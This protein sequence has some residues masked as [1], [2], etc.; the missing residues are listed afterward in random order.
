[1]LR[2]RAELRKMS[3]FQVELICFNFM[4]VVS[5][6]RNKAMKLTRSLILSCLVIVACSTQKP[7]AEQH[8]LTQEMPI[9]KDRESF[10]NKVS[11]GPS[12]TVSRTELSSSSPSS[13][14]LAVLVENP[15]EGGSPATSNGPLKTFLSGT[16]NTLTSFDHDNREDGEGLAQSWEMSSDGRQYTFHLKRGREWHSS[17]RGFSPSHEMNAEDVVFT[18]DRFMN[19]KNPLHNTPITKGNFSYWQFDDMANLV[20]GVEA[21]D[22][23]TVVFKL[24]QP[25]YLFPQIIS[26]LLLKR[27][28]CTTWPKVWINDWFRRTLIRTPQ[29][30]LPDRILIPCFVRSRTE[31]MGELKSDVIYGLDQIDLNVLHPYF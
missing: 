24:K 4:I 22:A 21:R 17:L 6:D 14:A 28:V 25:H 8:Q 7:I 5:S 13:D 31:W 19:E 29:G 26:Q 18:F 15:L 2:R 1:M 12:A 20:L 16:L 10:K 3:L 27:E 9:R 30:A 11:R 23:Q